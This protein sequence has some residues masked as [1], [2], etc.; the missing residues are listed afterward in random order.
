[1]TVSQI[2]KWNKLRNDRIRKGQV[3]KIE[4][5]RKRVIENV[6]EPKLIDE[7]LDSVADTTAIQQAPSGV[8]QPPLQEVSKGNAK[9]NASKAQK[10]TYY[11]VKS[12]DSLW[13]IARK[14]PGVTEQDL[15]KWNRCNANIRP[16]Q[17]L[18]IKKK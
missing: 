2:K 13:S 3:L 1:V 18:L 8:A 16:G 12:G 15:M 5:R 11:I 4:Q 17:K 6:T 10:N 14:Y 9:T 7:T